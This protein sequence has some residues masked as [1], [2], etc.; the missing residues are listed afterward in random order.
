MRN[1]KT[2]G[3]RLMT[4]LS[5]LDVIRG[6]AT[7]LIVIHH[8]SA[9]VLPDIPAVT[10]IFGAILWRI[11][12]IGWTGIDL[13][14]VLSGFFMGRTILTDLQE[15]GKIRLA[16]FWRRRFARIIPS[17]YVLLLVLGI[18]GASGYVNT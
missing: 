12:N 9:D 13:F 16:R 1:L 15:R 18:T 7:V 17:Y 10:G 2:D 4:R 6:L 3:N 11:R 14:F 8:T 5:G